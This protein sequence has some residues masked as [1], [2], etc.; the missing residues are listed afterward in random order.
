MADPTPA[1][2]PK[3]KRKPL[4]L[5][6]VILVALAGGGAGAFL[7]FKKPVAED[8]AAAAAEGEAEHGGVPVETGVISLEPFVTNLAA[9]DGDRYVKCTVRLEVD[10]REAAEKI[11][12]DE[13]SITKLRDGILT[14]LT[15]K[16]LDEV[17]SAEGK[18][19]LRDE[20]RQRVESAVEGTKVLHVY[21]TEFL[22]Q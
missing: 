16:R 12:T 2:A 21:Y 18:E 8:A 6:A 17:S 1:P 5:M 19:R 4:L 20:I 9:E 7:W 13:I 15:S 10:K 14:L 11:K 22:V 3:S